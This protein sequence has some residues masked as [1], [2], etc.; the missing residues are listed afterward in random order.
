MYWH[1]LLVVLQ[2]TVGTWYQ[3]NFTCKVHMGFL[4]MEMEVQYDVL[5]KDVKQCIWLPD[6]HCCVNTPIV[7]C[8]MSSCSRLFST[9]NFHITCHSQMLFFL[10]VFVLKLKFR[11][12]ACWCQRYFSIRTEQLKICLTVLLLSLKPVCSSDK[13]LIELYFQHHFAWM[14]N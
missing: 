7:L 2:F 10:F 8:S 4:Q 14:D 6:T 1:S 3:I 9:L 11:E 5:Q 12:R 13:S